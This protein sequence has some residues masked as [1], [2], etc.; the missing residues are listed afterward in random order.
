[1]LDFAAKLDHI[2]TNPAW[3]IPLG[4]G[5]SGA[6]RT[7]LQLVAYPHN[8]AVV[9]PKITQNYAVKNFKTDLKVVCYMCKCTV[10]SARHSTLRNISNHCIHRPACYSSSSVNNEAGGPKPYWIPTSDH[11]P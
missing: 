1:M 4:G 3:W 8:T 10:V 6:G 2:R 11:L 5:C 7:L 9:I